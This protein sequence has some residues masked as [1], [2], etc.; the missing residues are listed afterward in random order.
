MSSNNFININNDF[1]NIISENP[2]ENAIPLDF[3]VINLFSSQ[4]FIKGILSAR[5]NIFSQSRNGKRGYYTFSYPGL[6]WVQY[7][8]NSIESIY[9]LTQKKSAYELYNIYSNNKNNKRLRLHSLAAFIISKGDHFYNLYFG[10]EKAREFTKDNRLIYITFTNP[11]QGIVNTN[12]NTKKYT[13]DELISL[14]NTGIIKQ[15]NG[16]FPNQR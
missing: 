15:F 14:F 16:I 3:L 1:E 5:E 6:G 13:G 2:I 12:I 9:K 4:K 10:V 11:F 8:H 7:D